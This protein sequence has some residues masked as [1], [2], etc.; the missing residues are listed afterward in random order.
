ML[1]SEAQNK[2]NKKRDTVAS[3]AC[4]GKMPIRGVSRDAARIIGASTSVPVLHGAIE[5]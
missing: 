1:R 2:A 4:A 5:F 3:A